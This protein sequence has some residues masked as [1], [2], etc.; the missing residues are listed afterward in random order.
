[1]VPPARLAECDEAGTAR[2]ASIPIASRLAHD[3]ARRF[4]PES[5][6]N[7]LVYVVRADD[8]WTGT[9]VR[10][11]DVI[12]T[13]RGFRV[14]RL[15]ASPSWL[16]SVFGDRVL[17]IHDGVYAMWEVP[18]GH[19]LLDALS[20]AEYWRSTLAQ[21]QGRSG[22]G[23][24][25]WRELACASGQVHYFAVGDRGFEHRLV[26]EELA[27]D[28]AREAVLNGLRSAGV[29]G[30]APGYRDCQMKW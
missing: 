29:Y 11:V 8:A 22:A 17:E 2:F 26:L 15:P 30:G 4:A 9:R 5:P 19:Y 20:F 23:L 1:M 6:A 28:R 14:P 25:T 18:P 7:C 3:Q 16:P 12:L 27:P 24:G 21:A 13:P 10:R